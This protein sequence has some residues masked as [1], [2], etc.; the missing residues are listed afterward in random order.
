MQATHIEHIGIEV[1]NLDEAVK[2]Y[3]E[4]LGLRCYAIEEVRE[5][6]VKTALFRVGGT[7]VELL[8]STEPDGPIARFIQ[9]SGEGLHHIAIAV[10][11]L[12]HALKEVE[13]KGVE[14]IDKEPR[15]GAEGL[16]IAFLHPRSTHGVLLELCEGPTNMPVHR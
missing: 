7:K 5:Q 13:S 3:E 8:E 14:L 1:K 12:S 16:A 9:K 15:K 10:E 6:K 4:I 2:R 11:D